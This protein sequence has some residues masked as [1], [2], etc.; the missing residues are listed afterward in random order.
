MTPFFFSSLILFLVWLAF[1]FLSK[2]TRKEQLIMSTVGLVLAPALL[3][4]AGSNYRAIVPDQ[5]LSF[6][7]ED[8]L[9]AFSL[10]GIASIMYHNLLGKHIHRYKGDRLRLKNPVAHWIA[11]LILILGSWICLALGV[12]IAFSIPPMQA[13]LFGGAMIGVYVIASRNNLLIDAI[14]SGFMTALLVFIVE[15]LFFI[16]L[17]PNI[18]TNY[19]EWDMLSTFIIGGIPLEEILWAGIVG[20]TIGPMYEWLRR[21]SIK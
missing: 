6:G 2:K 14:L 12:I 5:A 11:H 21:Y 18:A 9:F 4:I 8:L 17:F 16:R 13:L 3:L 1:L 10:F 15:H 19:W 20:F 7:I